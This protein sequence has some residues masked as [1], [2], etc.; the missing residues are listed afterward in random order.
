MGQIFFITIRHPLLARAHLTAVTKTSAAN[1]GRAG[2]WLVGRCWTGGGRDEIWRNEW[3]WEG[4]ASAGSSCLAPS[5]REKHAL[6]DGDSGGPDNSGC[7]CVHVTHTHSPNDI[8]ATAIFTFCI[9]VNV[10]L[11]TRE[12]VAPNKVQCTIKTL[13]QKQDAALTASHFPG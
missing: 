12:I 1:Q 7:V 10:A 2:G 13:S 5:L 3:A 6:Q 11:L 9:L 4:W 8:V